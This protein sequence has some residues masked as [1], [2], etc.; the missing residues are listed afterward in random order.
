M[1]PSA[2]RVANRWWLK[3]SGAKSK[4]RVFDFDDTLVSS[5][6]SVTI[7][8]REGETHK[9]NSA[10]FAHYAPQD[11]DE[12]DFG[13][14]ND[15]YSPRIIKKNFEH[16]KGCSEQ[17]DTQT[18]ILT[19]RPKGSASAVQKFLEAQGVK[20]VHVVALASSDPYDKARWID[21]EIEGKGY[22]DVEFHDDSRANANAVKEH[23]E[24][25]KVEGVKFS[26]NNPPHPKEGDYSGPALKTDFKSDN[27]TTSKV[28]IEKKTPSKSEKPSGGKGDWWSSQTK[29]FQ[30][31][32]CQEHP[33]SQYCGH[34]TAMRDPNK[35]R[36]EQI[37]Q[38]AQ[39]ATPAVRAYVENHL[40]GKIDQAG[41]AAGIWLESLEAQV[42]K[43]KP[44]GLLR[45]F[46]KEDFESLK[47]VLSGD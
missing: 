1:N 4:L 5:E 32:Y 25:H 42:G 35:A 41:A 3:I 29:D 36:K 9:I 8:T 27:P 44:E 45:K 20:G 23:G 11:G 47:K 17:G 21:K 39:K 19:A 24:K 2:I 40:M 12:M 33:R 38:S 28:K 43:L 10:T 22:S 7:R 31:N 15:I 16:L 46:T 37:L 13:A 26:S 18:V 14:F 34:R 6:G 30:S